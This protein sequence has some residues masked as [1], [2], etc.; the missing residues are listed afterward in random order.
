MNNSFDAQFNA[1]PL[2]SQK[3]GMSITATDA[4]SLAFFPALMKYFTL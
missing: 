2:P 3:S 1:S 4:Q